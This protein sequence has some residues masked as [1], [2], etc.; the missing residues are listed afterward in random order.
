MKEMQAMTVLVVMFIT[1]GRA[2]LL[3][4]RCDSSPW[5]LSM[6]LAPWNCLLNEGV[7]QSFLPGRV[8]APRLQPG[9]GLLCRCRP[10]T[11]GELGACTSFFLKKPS[12][13][14]RQRAS[15]GGREGTF[16]LVM[17]PLGF[18]ALG[19][20]KAGPGEAI[21][22]PVPECQLLGRSPRPW[23]HSPSWQVKE[24]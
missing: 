11:Q 14:R 2:R 20:G 7:V 4:H 19:D 22:S 10:R 21:Y 8:L 6:E 17:G 16:V 5:V 13:P 23:Q 9:V 24:R 18:V 3:T 15:G 12:E 1:E